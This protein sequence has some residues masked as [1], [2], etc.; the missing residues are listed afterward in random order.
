MAHAVHRHGAPA[1]RVE[2]ERLITGRGTYASDW[3]L[4]G[5]LHAH[6]VRSDRAH[7][8]IVS[9]DVDAAAKPPGVRRIYTGEEKQLIVNGARND[10]RDIQRGARTSIHHL[11]FS[12]DPDTAAFICG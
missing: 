1:M 6:F 10:W 8:E 4:P 3:N 11:L 2:D 7:A 12:I 5:Q 9:I